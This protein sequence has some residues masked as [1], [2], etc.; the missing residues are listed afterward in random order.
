MSGKHFA[1]GTVISGIWWT[2]KKVRGRRRVR[3]IERER[4]RDNAIE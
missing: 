3:E 1:S 2:E 4:E